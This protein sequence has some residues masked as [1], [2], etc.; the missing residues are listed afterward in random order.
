MAVQLQIF[1]ERAAKLTHC[2]HM[3][4]PVIPLCKPLVNLI[5]LPTAKAVLHTMPV[6]ALHTHPPTPL[7]H[8]EL[9]LRLQREMAVH[10]LLFTSPDHKC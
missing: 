10:Y 4:L 9:L 1:S 5:S 2:Q 3:W 7:L 6:A 8:V